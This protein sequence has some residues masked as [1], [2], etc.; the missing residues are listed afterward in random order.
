MKSWTQRLNDA[1][2]QAH[3]E[4]RK[5]ALTEFA[6]DATRALEAMQRELAKAEIQLQRAAAIGKP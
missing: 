1:L 2:K 5:D 3:A 6:K 4:H